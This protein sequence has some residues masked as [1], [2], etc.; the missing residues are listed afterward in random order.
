MKVTYG[1]SVF[2]ELVNL[3]GY[4]A[5]EN[6]DAA[7]KFLDACDATFQ[8]LAVN[9]YVGAVKGHHRKELNGVRMWR[10]KGFAK[11]LIFY[12][13]K[14]GGVRILHIVHGAR[15]YQHLFEDEW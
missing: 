10:V 7:Q 5:F 1:P 9:Q 12:L 4:I 13:P 6:E 8:F 2:E 11:Y 14:P 15:D 3:S